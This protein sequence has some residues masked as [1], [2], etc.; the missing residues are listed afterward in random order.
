MQ[1]FDIGLKVVQ[2]VAWIFVGAY[3]WQ[4]SRHRVTTSQVD[5]L[6]DKV[7]ALQGEVDVLEERV[8]H[9]PTAPEV[10]ALTASVREM[11]AFFQGLQG[12]FKG[13]MLRLDRIEEYMQRG[14]T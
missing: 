14:T 2:F 13:V 8:R 4:Q 11:S 5:A 6:K 3:T 7:T 12:Q 10:A 9:L 1:Y